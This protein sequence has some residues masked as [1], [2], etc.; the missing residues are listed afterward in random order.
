VIR[1]QPVH[2]TA[3][4]SLW[5]QDALAA[6]P[7]AEQAEPL[8]GGH[9]ADICIV[10]G[11]YT[12][13]WTALRIKELDPSVD[14]M[15]LEADLC[16]SGASGRNGGLALGW[17]AKLGSLIHVCGVEEGLRLAHAAANAVA[18]IG[19]FCD[20]HGIDAHY[21]RHGWLRTATTP[22]HE[23]SLEESV[24]LCERHGLHVF[25]RLSPEELEART[26]SPG[27]VYG[28]L[29]PGA[30]TVQP[31]LLARGLRR[32]A[33]D[34]GVRIFERTPVLHIDPGQPPTIRTPR[35]AVVAD[36]IILAI[37][38]WGATL[39]D[40]RR[41]IIA[42]SSDIVATAPIPERLAEIGWTGGE[43]I[44]DARLTVHYSQ[45]TH[46]GR[47]VFGRGSGALAY[48]GRIT[49][50]FNQ[51]RSRAGVVTRGLHRI[52]PMLQDVPITHHWAGAVDRSR[53]NTLVFGRLDGQPHILYGVGYSGTGVAP[54]LIGGRILAS[55]ALDRI[56]EWSTSRLN[57][58]PQVLYPPEPIRFFG[59]IFVR[60][61]VRQKEDGEE[62]GQAAGR[63]TSAIAGLAA[64][65]YPKE[66][67][68]A[69][70]TRL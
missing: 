2:R 55:T 41:A 9:R 28:L 29:E 47:I 31:A 10:G 5:L 15:L 3:T 1:L 20:Q 57:Q 45:T 65:R 59:G 26:G 4:R 44:T 66:R 42:L 14:V 52:Y 16:G 38:A 58:G 49:N 69:R 27:N 17:W 24:R 25:Q 6:E 8:A 68:Q 12:G 51:H 22:L 64:P 34:K 11:G 18:E 67:K 60:E 23:Q 53:T 43:C 63:I 19:T 35:A 39:P 7:Y 54:S 62:A 70:Y 13:L 32:V 40:L 46:D 36:K 33:I 30:A 37:N 50:T 61:A 48:L 56:D 21:R